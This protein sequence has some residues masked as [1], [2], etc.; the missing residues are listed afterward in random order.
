MYG[1]GKR[2]LELVNLLQL[3]NKSQVVLFLDDNPTLAGSTVAGVPVVHPGEPGLGAHLATYEVNRVILASPHL[4]RASI[5][6]L[7]RS[8]S[9]QRISVQ[10]LPTI[11]E[12][13]AGQALA[14]EA[15]E[16][17]LGDLLGRD[18][19]PPD[20]ALLSA[21][22]TGKNIL[23]TGGGG[24]IGSEISRQ[25]LHLMPKRLVILEQSEENLYNITEEIQAAMASEKLLS[26]TV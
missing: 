2:G 1:A 4:D 12:V 22:V 6:R 17:T 25:C 20:S 23:I 21:S 3:S 26:N 10:S 15:R 9:G 14:G 11:N 19:V 5:R 8:A 7:V 16:I 13:V 24:S 18:E